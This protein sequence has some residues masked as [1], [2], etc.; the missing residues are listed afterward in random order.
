[1]STARHG[2]FLLL[3]VTFFI[4]MALVGCSEYN[5]IT[6]DH[7][8]I[9]SEPD[10]SDLTPEQNQ[11]E[12]YEVKWY[13]IG[14]KQYP[15]TNLVEN[16]IVKGLKDINTTVKIQVFPWSDYANNMS[17]IIASGEPFDICFMGTWTNYYPNVAKGA[18]IDMTDLVRLKLPN[19]YKKMNPVFLEGPKVKGRLYGLP[20][21]KE[22]FEAYG[23]E[24]DKAIAEGSGA[25]FS[26]VR[27][28]ADLTPI[29]KLAREKLPSDIFP[30][31]FTSTSVLRDSTFD[32]FG[33][34]M[35]PG[36]VRQNDASLQV[37]NQF[38]SPEFMG[39]WKLAYTWYQAGYINR[40]GAVKGSPDYWNQRKGLCRTETMGPMP[41]YAG[42]QNNTIQRVYIGNKVISTGSLIGAMMC[43]SKSSR[44]I[45][46][47]LLFYD[48]VNAK[49]DL[50]NLL[51]SGIKDR[52]YRVIDENTTPKRID[53]LNGQDENSVGYTHSGGAWSLGGDWFSSYLGKLD[54]A[55]RN[56]IVLKNNE[57]AIPSNLLGFSFDPEP[58]KT[59]IAACTNVYSELGIPLNCGAI[60]PDTNVPKFIEKLKA[61]GVDKIISEKQKQVNQWRLENDR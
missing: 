58:V 26:R 47:A 8:I 61:A 41:E 23:I 31:I 49:P 6:T 18:F 44:D 21:N 20:T 51:A 22:T 36:V 19:L 43:F 42:A 52:H 9:N 50:Y 33:D 7:P 16:E 24:V 25:D 5:T 60:D 48:T 13:M 2:L 56:E 45:D 34:I 38:E 39:N 46:R 32:S 53:Y 27:T 54:P 1:M 3:I 37:I 35:I 57:T 40:N 28:Y 29:L 59:E 30:M 12:P 15:E 17:M 14:T 11:W 55:D 10:I 4:S